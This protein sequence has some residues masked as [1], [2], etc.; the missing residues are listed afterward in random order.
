MYIVTVPLFAL[1]LAAALRRRLFFVPA[2][3][4]VLLSLIFDALTPRGLWLRLDLMQPHDP[5]V[6][7]LLALAAAWPVLARLVMTEIGASARAGTGLAR[8]ILVLLALYAGTRAALHERAIETMK[9]RI[10]EQGEPRGYA[11]LPSAGNPLV[12]TGIIEFE[13]AWKE[14]PIDL[15]HEYDPTSGKTRYKPAK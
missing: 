3:G 8:A 7:G 13:G 12:W 4:G 5:W 11:A 15:R 2:L 14:I 6:L 10:Y 1:T 9:S